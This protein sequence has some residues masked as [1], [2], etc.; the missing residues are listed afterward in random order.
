VV[1]DFP[2]L[3]AI[4]GKK[5]ITRGIELFKQGVTT[6]T[7]WA[8]R[9]V[10]EFGDKVKRRI[11]DLWI[12]VKNFVALPGSSRR[13]SVSNR[14]S[15]MIERV[16][17]F[18]ITKPT[19]K[20]QGETGYGFGVGEGE[21]ASKIEEKKTL[22]DAEKKI[23][24]EK[25]SSQKRL[26]DLRESFKQ[27]NFDQ[28]LGRK[29]MVELAKEIL[30]PNEQAKMLQGIATAKTD[31]QFEKLGLRMAHAAWRIRQT[32]AYKTLRST[33]NQVKMKKLKPDLR[34]VMTEILSA[35]KGPSPDVASIAKKIR[36]LLE[37]YKSQGIKLPKGIAKLLSEPIQRM[38]S[39]QIMEVANWIGAVEEINRQE[40][41]ADFSERKT[42]LHRIAR[43]AE[44][45]IERQADEATGTETGRFRDFFNASLD[46]EAV[47]A[48]LG[49]AAKQIFYDARKA[50]ET[51]YLKLFHTGEDILR[52]AIKKAG[53]DPDSDKYMKWINEE[54][55]AAG[56]KM[57]RND[58][59]ALLANLSDSQS[60][61][62]IV[63]FTTKTGK[64]IPGS[65][66]R[67]GSDVS[68]RKTVFTEAM[69]N[70]V[71]AS[72]TK[73]EKIIIAETKRFLNG[74]LRDKLNTVSMRLLG[75][76][77]A[78]REDYFPLLRDMKE[79]KN[80]G[81]NE[82]FRLYAKRELEGSG[83]LK[84]RT[85]NKNPVIISDF[86]GT[87]NN[88]IKRVSN[89]ISFGENIRDSEIIL[90]TGTLEKTIDRKYGVKFVA[91]LRD[92]MEAVKDHGRIGGGEM[93]K[94]L[95]SIM[96]KIGSAYLAINP[97]SWLKQFGGIF[98]MIT[99]MSGSD[100]AKAITTAPGRMEEV[101][102]KIWGYSP[103]LR[104]RY[105]DSGLQMLSPVFEEERGKAV[106]YPWWH[107]KSPLKGLQYSDRV[108]ATIC[109]LGTEMKL[110]RENPGMKEDDLQVKVAREVEKII[111]RT[112]N[113]TSVVDMSGL[114]LESR[115]SSALKILTAFQSQGNKNL[116]LLLRS[117]AKYKA[118][119]IT[120]GQ[121]GIHLSSVILGNALWV[122][123]VN[124]LMKGLLGGGGG[125]D[126]D[127]KAT[128][129]DYVKNISFDILTENISNI[130]GGSNIVMPAIKAVK[131][132]IEGKPISP[133][134]MKTENIL[135]RTV[136][137]SYQGMADAVKMI[138]NWKE[139]DTTKARAFGVKSID[140]AVRGFL[141][142]LYGVPVFPG[143]VLSKLVRGYNE[144]E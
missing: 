74:T 114:A 30:P 41:I 110:K 6:F 103:Q 39:K 111:D 115:K 25:E 16:K 89:Y 92:Q 76:E 19:G 100:L 116:N 95:G 67:L 105:S 27:A 36:S 113:T 63:G 81:E 20:T 126:K 8:G 118:G 128:M 5:A 61:K 35:I 46:A 132:G 71:E 73:E 48:K 72:A 123:A 98:P 80:R 134:Q 90:G 1:A 3:I 104:E 120:A 93:N 77:P 121:F 9:M 131:A 55:N 142:L 65:G 133:Q 68:A 21:I 31:T 54:V 83:F 140:D 88:H 79:N 28:E 91:L 69:A 127:K 143:T 40:K 58:K 109:W 33:L 119:E 124:A 141:P 60:R 12:A 138:S 108:N 102:K 129:G 2:V 56:L 136:D 66:I 82:A 70:Q 18:A 137:Q 10:R 122:M 64:K 32:S 75:Y 59:L 84:E 47:A 130:Y 112:Q 117:Y 97:R 14:P 57:T 24:T 49:K 99:E 135:S 44:A 37:Y 139:G 43:E 107:W 52:D 34:Q 51:V 87:Y 4:V 7:Q 86:V 101:R 17:Q 53:I 96:H 11:A 29:A 26:K 62:E 22:L 144:N 13:G 85:K 38:S 94:W 42:E 50:A 15:S 106:K 125:D 45:H 23:S 78:I